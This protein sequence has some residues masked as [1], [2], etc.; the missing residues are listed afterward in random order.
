MATQATK[1]STPAPSKPLAVSAEST[2]PPDLQPGQGHGR[3]GQDGAAG[4]E[5]P[6]AAKAPPH[7]PP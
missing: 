7:S 6:P 1:T 5:R 2:T 4:D 3:D